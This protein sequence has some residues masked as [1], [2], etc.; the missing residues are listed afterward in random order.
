M[1][2]TVRLIT[3]MTD[4]RRCCETWVKK[5]P[6]AKR[7]VLG[8]VVCDGVRNLFSIA[9]RS[10]F[11]PMPQCTDGQASGVRG[12]CTVWCVLRL[13]QERLVFRG[14][15]PLHALNDWLRVPHRCRY[16]VLVGVRF[17]GL[18]VLRFGVSRVSNRER[19][20]SLGLVC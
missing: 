16:P 14:I 4:D 15:L 17:A 20:Q 11:Y 2:S 9:R 7:T 3:E 1:S 19:L 8:I 13:G 12:S 10:I 5:Y 6:D 18:E